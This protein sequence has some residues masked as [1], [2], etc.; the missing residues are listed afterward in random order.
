[1]EEMGNKVKRNKTYCY[2]CKKPTKQLI[3]SKATENICY[4]CAT[5]KTIGKKSKVLMFLSNIIKL[6]FLLVGFILFIVSFAIIV[7][8]QLLVKA[9]KGLFKKK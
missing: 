1:M 4:E 7:S 5:N 3:S 9:V 2:V 8:W 6:P